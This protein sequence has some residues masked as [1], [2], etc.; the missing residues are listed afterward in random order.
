MEQSW[1]QNNEYDCHIY[2]FVTFSQ[3]LHSKNVRE[4]EIE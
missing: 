3:K 2:C 1:Q 4:I